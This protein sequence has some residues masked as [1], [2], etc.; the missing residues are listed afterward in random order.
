MTTNTSFANLTDQELIAETKRLATAERL[1]T[2]ALIRSL[3]ELDA[4]RL[5]L[6]ESCASLFTYCT[7]VLHLSEDAAYNRME[8]ARAARRFPA[9]LD[10]LDEGTLTL[11]AARRL[12]PHLTN[13]N[14]AAVLAAASFKTKSEIE[15]LIVALAPKPD[16]KSLIRK[17]PQAA[18]A[19]QSAMP[20][21]PVMLS[22]SPGETQESLGTQR[23]NPTV[24]QSDV[25][26]LAPERYRIQF[27]IGRETRH[28]LREVQALMR[29]SIPNGDLSEIFDRAVTLLLKEARRQTFADCDK[30]RASRATSPGSRCIPAAVRRTVRKRDQDRCTFV[31]A[32]GRCTETSL[33]QFHHDEP[34]AVGG[35]ATVENI[36][37]RCAAHNRYEAELFFGVN[38]PGIVRETRPAWPS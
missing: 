29:H 9:V 13:E 24:D 27:T 15:E 34:F 38:Y 26:P 10:A 33:L 12:A 30:P 8:V 22:V 28:K 3:M 23:V 19:P 7:Q 11:T 35:Q 37:L 36:H 21:P 5:Y 20:A 16:A 4:R 2:A 25:R 14:C 6:A 32:N 31:G 1:A 18:P 17:L